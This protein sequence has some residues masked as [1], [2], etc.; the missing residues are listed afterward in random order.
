VGPLESAGILKKSGVQVYK[1]N[2]CP[3]HRKRAISHMFRKEKVRN[4]YFRS[5]YCEL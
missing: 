1:K 5:Q 2:A 3:A 4:N